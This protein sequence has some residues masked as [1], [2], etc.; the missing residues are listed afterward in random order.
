V[1]NNPEHLEDMQ[2]LVTM[3][4]ATVHQ[5]SASL[6]DAL[7]LSQELHRLIPEM[8]AVLQATVNQDTTI[9]KLQIALHE[10]YDLTP[11]IRSS[12]VDLDKMRQGL[13]VVR[14]MI[15]D[16]EQL[17]K[18]MPYFSSML[19]H[20]SMIVSQLNSSTA[21][22]D[23]MRQGLAVV[24]E[25]ITDLEQLR[26][27]FSSIL[28]Q[29][30]IISGEFAQANYLAMQQATDRL[31]KADPGNIQEVVSSQVEIINAYYQS[32]L[33]QSQQSFRWSLIWGGIGLV[34]LMAAVGFVLFRQPTNIAVF[35]GIGG[36]IGEAIAATYLYIYRH[37]SDQ[38]ASFQVSL[39]SNQ[40]ILTAN[41]LCENMPD[42]LKQKTRA[43]LVQKIAASVGQLQ[44]M[45]KKV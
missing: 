25:I 29:L 36:A 9:K 24:R 2:G 1:A 14:E 27:S 21:D 41:S 31:A 28:S 35:S 23:R 17:Q 16:L 8:T 6:Q 7:I 13:T 5:Q 30:S 38:L 42:D 37:A 22:L 34:F 10:L 40:R 4:Q 43:E 11:D 19:S 3:L 39:E 45:P 32:G 18:L 12:V 44:M 20:F 15:K 26:P 33:Q